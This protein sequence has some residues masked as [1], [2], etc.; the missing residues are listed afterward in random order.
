MQA[1][2][3][4]KIMT[5][6]HHS[7]HLEEIDG[8]YAIYRYT[9]DSVEEKCWGKIKFKIEDGSYGVIEY[10]DDGGSPEWKENVCQAIAHAFRHRKK[11]NNN[12]PPEVLRFAA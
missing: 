3:A 6:R 7:A 5:Y 9:P 1:L 10:A 11:E 8:E 4:H 12:K 2:G